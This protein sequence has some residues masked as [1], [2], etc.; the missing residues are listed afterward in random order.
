MFSYFRNFFSVK[1]EQIPK[2]VAIFSDAHLIDISVPYSSDT[3][4]V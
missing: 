2:L 1:I 3:F 4:F